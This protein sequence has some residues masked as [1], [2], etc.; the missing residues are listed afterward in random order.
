[1]LSNIRKFKEEGIDS[2]KEIFSTIFNWVAQPRYDYNT[3]SSDAINHYSCN[4][5]A[6]NK[7]RN[8]NICQSSMSTKKESFR[9]LN[10]IRL[11]VKVKSDGENETDIL[12][13]ESVCPIN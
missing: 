8:L 5:G 4:S 6:M 2:T 12:S 9:R 1:M 10:N 3:E 7:L 13:D 11:I